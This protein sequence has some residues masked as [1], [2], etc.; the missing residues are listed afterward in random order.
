MPGWFWVL[1]AICGTLGVAM[2]GWSYFRADVAGGP[3]QLP[4]RARA[5]GFVGLM[6]ISWS[7]VIVVVGGAI[8]L[9]EVLNR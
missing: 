7:I 4:P 5:I 6:L 9:A 3:A 2:F 8:E 1:V